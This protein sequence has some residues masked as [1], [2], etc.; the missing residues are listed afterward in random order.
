MQTLL[1]PAP[2]GRGARGTPTGLPSVGVPVRKRRAV[3]GPQHDYSHRSASP[4]PPTR[5][6]GGLLGTQGARQEDPGQG[7]GAGGSLSVL[8]KPVATT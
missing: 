2:A 7:W 8:R 5:P 1:S 4:E 6:P 3:G